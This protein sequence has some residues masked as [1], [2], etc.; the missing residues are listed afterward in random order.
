[1]TQSDSFSSPNPYQRDDGWY[2]YDE[3]GAEVGPY[4]TEDEALT[5]LLQYIK[6]NDL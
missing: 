4:D 2:F 6:D 5:D 1:M 3:T